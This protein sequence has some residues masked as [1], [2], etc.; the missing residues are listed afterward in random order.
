MDI[1]KGNMQKPIYQQIREDLLMH[2][3]A[4]GEEQLPPERE[5]CRRYG[6]CRP[7][8]HKALSYLVEND[9]IVR[10]PGK[11]SFFRMQ[12]PVRP[13]IAAGIKLVIRRDWKEWS[14]DCYFGMTVQGIC[15]SLN[16]LGVN[17]TI[18]QFSDKLLLELLPEDGA[19][20]I[21]LS[22][23]KPEEEVIRTLADAGRP[24]TVINRLLRHP[25]VN[26][27][28]SDHVKDGESV[29]R[30][31]LQNGSRRMI[32]F[33]QESDSGLASGRMEGIRNVLGEELPY[34]QISLPVRDIGSAMAAA[35]ESLRSELADAFVLLNSKAL[36]EPALKLF[37]SPEQLLL[38]ADNTEP[39]LHGVNLI[40]MPVTEIGQRAGHAAATGNPESS[41]ILLPGT[42]LPARQSSLAMQ[43]ENA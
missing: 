18:E 40:V 22:P 25:G 20:S 2:F 7:T 16:K 42:L 39:L 9:L 15:G 41:R 14:T 33:L 31:A 29:A 4:T 27:I 30:F 32:Y 28:S 26:V 3:R 24:V 36:L 35:V 17:L 23:E 43:P 12:E 1:P 19:P 13:R 21:W 5:L 8:V 11:G 34:R 10:R 38:F 37:P 6:V